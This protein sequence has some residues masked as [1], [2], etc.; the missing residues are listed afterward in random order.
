LDRVVHEEPL[1]LQVNGR[2]IAVLMRTPGEDLDLVGGFLLTEQIVDSLAEVSSIRH[3]T[4][5]PDPSAMDNVVR[6]VLKPEV[7]VDLARLSRHFFGS[8]SCGVCGKATLEQLKIVAS[9]LP[10]GL[11]VT[12]PMLFGMMRGLESNQRVFEL[13]GGVHGAALFS[14][15]G[16]HRVT[17]EDVGRHNAVDKV[18]GFCAQ[19]DEDWLTKSVLVVSGRVSFEIVQKA[20][21]VG[22]S[23]IVAVSAPSSLAIETARA[24]NMTLIG[25]M[26]GEGFNIYAGS[27]RISETQFVTGEL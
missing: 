4:E 14:F 7:E 17:R 6:V 25:F 21:L 16:K 26:R 13:T 2:S 3:C 9:P 10:D 11:S 18:I 8:S 15:D 27:H 20:L 22:I 1:E 12:I 24:Y 23:I 5:I 19:E